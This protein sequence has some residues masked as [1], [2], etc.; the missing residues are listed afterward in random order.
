MEWYSVAVTVVSFYRRGKIDTPS[1][2]SLCWGFADGTGNRKQPRPQ[3]TK[4][5]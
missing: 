5:S 4:K 1:Q 2:Y 3:V